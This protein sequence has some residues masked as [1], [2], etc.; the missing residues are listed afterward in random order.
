MR[1]CEKSWESR[2]QCNKVL[3]MFCTAFSQLSLYT[4]LMV[5]SI[6]TLQSSG[7]GTECQRAMAQICRKIREGVRVSQV[8][9]SN[10]FRCLEKLVLPSIFGTCL[11]SFMIWNLHGE[12]SNDSFEWKKCDILGGSKH[13]LSLWPSYIFSGWSRPLNPHGLR[14]YQR[15]HKAFLF[16]SFGILLPCSLMAVS[17]S[18]DKAM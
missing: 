18:E 6:H 16:L 15:E 14:P 10:C 3:R 12:L 7:V 2:V 5:S 13:I 11:S 9:S 4:V 8:K 17:D 1:L